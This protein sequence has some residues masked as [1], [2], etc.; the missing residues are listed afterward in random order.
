MEI[1][2]N[3]VIAQF[4]T[5]LDHDHAHGLKDGIVSFSGYT[6]GAVKIGSNVWIGDKCTILKGTV[7]GDNVIVGAITLIN[8]DVPSNCIVVG[9][10]CRVV[11]RFV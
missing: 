2:D 5:V 4:V 8:C 6:T 3:V 11:K 1:G 9:N 10:P 7:I